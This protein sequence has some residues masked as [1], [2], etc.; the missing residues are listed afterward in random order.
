MYHNPGFE[1]KYKKYKRGF[2]SE[3][4]QFLGVEFSIYLDRR[5]FVM[6]RDEE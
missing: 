3:N 5:V 6:R 1:Q 2:L 4:F